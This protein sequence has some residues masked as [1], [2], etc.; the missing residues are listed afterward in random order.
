MNR[1]S[2][3]LLTAAAVAAGG[4]AWWYANSGDTPAAGIG[5]VSA[6]DAADVDTSMVQEMALG[7]EDAPVTVIEYASFTCP[8][9]QNFHETVYGKLKQNYID[10]GK[11]RFIYREVYFDRF[12]LW[13]GMVAR[14][15]G[16]GRYFG[17]VDILFDTQKEWIGSGEPTVI[18]NNL[19]KIGRTAGMSDETIN[20]C[21][22]DETNAKAMVA[23]YQKNATADEVTGTPTFFVNGTRYSNMGYDEFAKILDAEIA[24]G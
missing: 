19:R 13:A 2:F 9:C 7:A 15:G 17:I 10:T 22:N 11:V 18:A 24:K 14:C 4:G 8:H 12:G 23:L 1:R 3:L 21:L 20:T 16:E 6:Q 5:S